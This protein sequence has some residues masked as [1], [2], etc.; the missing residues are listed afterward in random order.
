LVPFYSAIDSE[1]DLAASLV[2]LRMQ[3]K[4]IDKATEGMMVQTVEMPF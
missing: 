1:E 4:E 2:L 3:P